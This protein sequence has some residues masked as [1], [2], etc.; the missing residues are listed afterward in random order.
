MQIPILRYSSGKFQKLIILRS[1]IS[2]VYDDV[3]NY[4]K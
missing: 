3:R 2:P 1:T 4:S